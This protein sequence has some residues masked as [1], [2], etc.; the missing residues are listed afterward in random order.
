MFHLHVV[1]FPAVC[2]WYCGCFLD[3]RFPRRA[4]S[5][6]AKLEFKSDRFALVV[7][8]MVVRVFCWC[9][10]FRDR[11][12]CGRY[13]VQFSKCH[14]AGL[15]VMLFFCGRAILSC[16]FVCI[17]F[18][19]LVGVVICWG[20]TWFLWV[21]ISASIRTCDFIWIFFWRLD[22]VSAILLLYVSFCNL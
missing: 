11:I 21:T 15:V 7:R 1:W 20:P 22:F 17:G 19:C 14:V 2:R 10:R 3:L 13:S 9:V 6:A 18:L 5:L 8:F 12:L 4:R 16:L